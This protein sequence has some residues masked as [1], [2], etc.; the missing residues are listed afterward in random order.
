MADEKEATQ[1]NTEVADKDSTEEALYDNTE[2][3]EEK[4]EEVTEDAKEESETEQE[5]KE[6]KQE[7]K[8]EDK[9]EGEEEDEEFKDESPEKYE[10]NLAEESLLDQTDVDRITADARELG[11]SNED[12]QEMLTLESEAISR[13]QVKIDDNV[14]EV[15]EA[16]KKEAEKDKEIGG[17]NFKESVELANRVIERFGSDS[18][19]ESLNKTSFGDHPEV[20]RI[21]SKIGKLMADDKL[22]I[23]NSQSPGGEVPVEELF[24]GNSMNTN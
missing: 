17:E 2:S 18:L 16:W 23:P 13:Y 8:A 7:A 14:K 22:V 20:I 21:F 4:K 11:L 19:R 6:E 12:A 9:K 3:T 15:R 5:T 1:D 10:L 24:Y